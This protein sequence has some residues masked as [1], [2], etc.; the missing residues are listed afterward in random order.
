MESKIDTLFM[1]WCTVFPLVLF[2]GGIEIG[3]IQSQST[4][5]LFAREIAKYSRYYIEYSDGDFLSPTPQVNP[6]DAAK[7]N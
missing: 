4:L 1:I 6:D 7:D 5:R 3:R 2:L